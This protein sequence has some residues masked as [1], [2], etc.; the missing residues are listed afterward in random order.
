M[1]GP[2]MDYMD[3]S[4]DFE[5]A[6]TKSSRTNDL[7]KGGTSVAASGGVGSTSG[8]ESLLDSSNGS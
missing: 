3:A 4:K 1:R 7:V 8:L 6:Q 2:M 5:S